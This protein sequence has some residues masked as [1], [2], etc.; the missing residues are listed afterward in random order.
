MRIAFYIEPAV[1][2]GNPLW[3][4]G[5]IDGFSKNIGRS[6]LQ[7]EPNAEFIFVIPEALQ[8]T[9]IAHFPDSH[10]IAIAH[11]DIIDKF[12]PSSRGIVNAWYRKSATEAQLAGMSELIR[13]KAPEITPDICISYSPAPFLEMLWPDCNI[14]Y[15]EFGIFSRTPFEPTVFIDNQGVLA[16]STSSIAAAEVKQKPVSRQALD[17]MD[18]YRAHLYNFFTSTANPL[19]SILRESSEQFDGLILCPLQFSNFYAFDAHCAF[20]TQYHFLLHVLETTPPGY[21]VVVCDHPE[22]PVLSD[23]TAKYLN[24]KYG[25]LVWHSAFRNIYAASSYIFP[26]VD[27]VVS[28][29]SSVGMHSLFWQ[30]PLVSLGDGPLAAYCDARHLSELDSIIK[31]EPPEWKS[32]ALINLLKFLHLPIDYL[33]ETNNF[34]A[35]FA[36]EKKVSLQDYVDACESIGWDENRFIDFYNKLCQRSIAPPSA[37]RSDDVIFTSSLFWIGSDGSALESQSMRQLVSFLTD[38]IVEVCYHLDDIDEEI[39]IFELGF[40][41]TRIT[42]IV[43]DIEVLVGEDRVWSL[44][45]QLQKNISLSS[46][47]LIILRNGGSLMVQNLT[48]D[49]R[50]HIELDRCLDLTDNQMLKVRYKTSLGHVSIIEQSVKKM[51]HQITLYQNIVR[52]QSLLLDQVAKFAKSRDSWCSRF[53]VRL[54]RLVARHFGRRN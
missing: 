23:Q 9:V 52:S 40:A 47:G 32:R 37:L 20:E 12:G 42:Q 28:V 30:K 51:E 22:H 7:N 25:N 13:S 3:K 21:G 35:F 39:S 11:K 5:W 15:V 49:G 29:S 50:L 33:S 46:E 17:V 24:S 10:I 54:F 16:H 19:G 38:D 26:Y 8:E 48:A 45:N 4:A 34:L 43:S 44:N 14:S 6:I 53:S 1:E 27:A 18:R 36:N 41:D 31:D 2:M